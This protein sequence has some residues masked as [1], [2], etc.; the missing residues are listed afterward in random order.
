MRRL[1]LTSLLLLSA[2]AT[3]KQTV[4]VTTFGACYNKSLPLLLDATDMKGLFQAISAEFCPAGCPE[5]TQLGP[6][7]AA[8]PGEQRGPVVLVTDFVDLQ[9]FVP[10]PSGLLMGEV[11]RT[12]LNNVC[13]YQVL[14]GEFGKYFTLTE[15][16]LVV[17][18]RRARE[19][20]SNDYGE[21]QAIIGTYS[22]LSNNKLMIF[23]RRIDTRTGRVEKMVSREVDYTCGGPLTRYSVH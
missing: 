15:G 22:Y 23:A 16:G 6:K 12:T 2:C 5:S 4:S 13:N 3:E 14:Q 18:T 11:M 10:N 21:R 19:I 1:L 8:C 17:L 7:Q 9:S 20:K